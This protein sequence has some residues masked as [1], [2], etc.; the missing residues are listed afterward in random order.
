MQCMR[1]DWYYSRQCVV[2]G[3]S[4]QCTTV[5]TPTPYGGTVPSSTYSG[6]LLH[7]EEEPAR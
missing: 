5:S 4:M 3:D 2:E 7:H 6:I 1:T